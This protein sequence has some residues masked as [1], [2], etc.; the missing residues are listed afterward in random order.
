MA[1]ELSREELKRNELGEAVEAGVSFAEKHLRV[2]L[3]IVIGVVAVA[4]AGWAVFAWRGARLDSASEALGRAQRVASA[5]IVDSGARPDDA[6]RPTFATAA[7]R[8]AQARQLFDAVVQQYDGTGAARAARLRLAELAFA[9]GD[10]AAARAHYVAVGTS[11]DALGV[12][13]AIGLAAVDRAE[14]RGA[15]LITRLQN[16]LANARGPL[17][18]DLLLVELAR[19]H[20]ALGNRADARAAWQRLV[21]E[22]PGSAWAAEARGQLA[23]SASASR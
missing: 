19:T 3:G 11:D 22:H 20:A 14:G 5:E 15:E 13:A 17:P 7:E 1:H 8:D 16:D 12:G 2:I 18:A 23:G 21:D 6:V 4:L 9:A 10:F